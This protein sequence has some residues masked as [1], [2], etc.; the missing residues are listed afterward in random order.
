MKIGLI[1]DTHG[2]VPAWHKA[3]VR[4]A[5]A[6][7]IL[8]AGDILYHPPRLDIAPGYDIPGLVELLNASPIPIMLARGNC[9]AEVYEE[10]L[11][12]PVLSPYAFAR[13]G[14]LRIMVTHGHTFNSE[15]MSHLAE[16]RRTDILVTGHTHLP[17]IERIGAMIHVNPGSP[18]LP[19]FERSG[20]LTPTVGL[21]QD[22]KV[23][24]VELENGAEIMSMHLT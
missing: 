6:D 2:S 8:H 4:F 11:E 22:G 19:K 10:L 17:L 7:L 13:F 23:A 5:G 3:M 12:I 20:I 21:I 16:R 1:S 24:I 18:T 14:D 15:S 9:D